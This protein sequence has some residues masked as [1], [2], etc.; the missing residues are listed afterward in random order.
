[1]R[2][3]D[4]GGALAEIK[5]KAAETAGEGA[6]HLLTFSKA[7]LRMRLNEAPAR[8]R[9]GDGYA[10]W[11]TRDDKRA[12]SNFKVLLASCRSKYF[13]YETFWMGKNLSSLSY[14]QTVLT[15]LTE[16]NIKE[17]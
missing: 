11:L 3:A 5:L 2:R 12:Q 8:I 13:Y 9:R 16:Y 7:L 1:M 17:N 6:D 4:R 10:I 14:L 15:T